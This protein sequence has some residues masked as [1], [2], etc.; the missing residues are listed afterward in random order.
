MNLAVDVRAR[1]PIIYAIAVAD[2]EAR[3]GAIPPDRMLDEPRKRLRKSR[4][5]L[6]GINPLRHRF[7]NVGA[8]TGLIAGSTIRMVGLESCQDASADQK[9]VH[10][11]IDG[12]HAGADL[13]PEVEAFRGGQQDAGQGHGQDLVRNAIDLPERSD[14]TFPQSAEPIGAGWVIGILELPVDPSDQV[15]VGDVANE[16][17]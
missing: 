3:L 9:V 17:E 4:I 14:Q 13:A 6:P 11:S 7:Y 16:Q 15:A 5:E 12:N 2:V 1:L 10:Q 8:A